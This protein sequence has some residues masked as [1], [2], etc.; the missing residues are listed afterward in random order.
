MA[1]VR[2]DSLTQRWLPCL[3]LQRQ[4]SMP[5]Q[6]DRIREELLECQQAHHALLRL[7]ETCDVLFSFA[8][9]QYD[10]HEIRRRARTNKYRYNLPYTY[11]VPK[12]P[13]RYAFYRAAGVLCRSTC[14]VREVV[15]PAREHNLDEVA[16]RYGIDRN[17]F[18]V[19]SRGL[20][21]IWPL[22]SSSL[23]LS[24]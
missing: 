1:Q 17:R 19:I 22:L 23:R 20:C 11:M 4:S 14:A 16:E 12:F 18:R 2:L 3:R 9:A 13:W 10:G 7:S 24:G 6:R 21:N 5:W 8:R 15:D